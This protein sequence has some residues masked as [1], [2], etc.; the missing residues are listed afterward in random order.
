MSD[1]LLPT[2]AMMGLTF[3]IAFFVAFII[4][5][6]VTAADSL[7]FYS[8]HQRELLRLRRMKK[9]HQKI[10]LIM[11]E[12]PTAFDEFGDD[13]REDY[14]RGINRDFD[15]YEGYYHGVSPGF[16]NE[17]LVHYYYPEDTR[18][19]FLR[20]AEKIKNNRNKKRND[21]SEEE[22]NENRNEKE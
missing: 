22:E 10:L 12:A 2:L 20:S 21:K 18:I 6:I 9:L 19:M 15:N 3:A 1:L 11:R 14:V 13:K 16:P 7:D 4:K 17:N 5:L 8:S